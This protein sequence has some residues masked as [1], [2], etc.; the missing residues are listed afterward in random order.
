LDALL[1]V[2]RQ[3]TDGGLRSCIIV[4]GLHRSGTS[5][6]ARLINLLG[7]DIAQ[8]LLRKTAHNERGYWESRAVVRVHNRLLNAIDPTHRGP[9]DPMPLPDNWP[10]T[11]VAQ[12]AKRQLTSIIEKEFVDSSLFVVKD[13]RISRLL[14]LWVELLQ[15]LEI[16]P[17][18]VIPFRNPLEVAASL[19]ERD[20]VLLPQ[21]LLLYIHSYLETELA[22][23][24]VRRVFVGYDHLLKHWQLFARRLSETSGGLVPLPSEGVTMEIDN[25]LTTDLYHHR[26]TRTQMVLY[27]AVPTAIVD[28]FDAMEEVA[29][30][31]DETVLRRSFD[32]F[33]VNVDDA[34][35][36]YHGFLL[37]L[38]HSFES[39]T[40]WRITAPLRWLKTI[41]SSSPNLCSPSAGTPRER[42]QIGTS[43]RR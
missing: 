15:D 24:T 14:P 37:D 12:E 31:G 20:Q 7:A 16:A 25:F 9:L 36:L 42:P 40:C 1:D 30:T 29:K 38:R 33:R 8:D 2:C 13:P 5:A 27:P 43:A 6:V 4:C 11:A 21:A 28:M 3:G 41:V 18:V 10:A 17:I 32:R 26:F 35:K 22:S 39:S 19:A 34:F 23:R